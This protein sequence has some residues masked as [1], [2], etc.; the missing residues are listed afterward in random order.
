MKDLAFLEYTFVFEPSIDTWSRGTDFETDLSDF[1]AAH[2]LQAN[3]VNVVGGS[4]RRVIYIQRADK[5]DSA[6][7]DQAQVAAQPMAKTPKQ[8]IKEAMKSARTG[9]K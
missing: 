6:K 5:I 8:A 9:G 7:A 4:T 2:G 3:I 1:L